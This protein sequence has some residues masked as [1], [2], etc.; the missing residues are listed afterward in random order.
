[1]DKYIPGTEYPFVDFRMEAGAIWQTPQI[2]RFIPQNKAIDD[3]MTRLERHINSNP[4][5]IWLR[6]KGENFEISNSSNA[7][8]LEYE[9]RP[10]VNVPTSP[11]PSDPFNLITIQERLIEEQGVTT[12]AMGKIPSGVRANA[13]IE[14]LKASEFSNLTMNTK[15]LKKTI[16]KAASK[17]LFLADTYL[18][19]VREV[20]Y[21]QGGE[22]QY[23]DVIG[24]TGAD[25]RQNKLQE[26]LPPNTIVLDSS[27]RVR[28]EVE[29]GPGYTV[30]GKRANMLDLSNFFMAMAKEGL[31]NPEAM[32]LIIEKLL[33]TYQFGSTSE[34]LEEY[35]K[36]SGQQSQQVDE[37]MKNQIKLSVAEVIRDLQGGVG[38]SPPP[39]ANPQPGAAGAEAAQTSNLPPQGV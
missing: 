16:E 1:M 38:S 37:K 3:V 13:A 33:D 2:E 25:V 22:A 17:I 18:M 35:D 28:I 9:G 6:Q 34:F 20:S 32:R 21:Y 36:F 30:E 14:T 23:F 29:T 8:V 27:D 5:G 31:V 26:Q 10:P 39:T 15:M 7:Y 11:M 12:T 4:M 19:N 24:K